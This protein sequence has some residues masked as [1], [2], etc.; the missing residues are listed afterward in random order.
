[1]ELSMR[2]RKELTVRQAR[3][4][5]QVSRAVKAK[6]LDE[7]VE[8][9]GYNRDYA[10]MLLRGCG[11]DRVQ[12]TG[13]GDSV[14]LVA[15]T[16]CRKAGGRPV[17][18]GAQVRR[19]VERLWVLFGHL[20]GK[21][22]VVLIREVLVSVEQHPELRISA[23]TCTALARVSA[24]TVDRMLHDQR[25]RLRLKGIS[26][27]KPTSALIA[28][29]PIR[30][31]TEWVGVGP[32]HLQIDLVGHDGGYASGEFCFT[33]VA[34]DVCSGWSELR[35]LRNKAAKWV[36]AALQEIRRELPFPV[37]E[38]HPD[39]GSE[40]L[41]HA[42]ADYCR[43]TQIR[44]TR[45]RPGRKND[46]CYVE[47]KNFDLVRK[48]VGYPR[49]EGDQAVELLN[50]LYRLGSSLW[51][52]YYPSQKLLETHRQGSTVRKRFDK[53]RSPARRLLDRNELSP[54][55]RW[56]LGVRMKQTDAIEIA[57]QV[58][59]LQSRVFA[60][61]IRHPVPGSNTTEVSA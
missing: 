5:R 32:G 25:V 29:I 23:T 55:Q 43:D 14:R 1:M 24:A 51:N 35:A 31:F 10:A 33:L 61:A 39:N 21:R 27:T 20:C 11:L 41:N 49:Y 30:T 18:Y 17:V 40:F 7:F 15:T 12:S 52:L 8:A 4:Y 58:R 45:S 50:Q 59:R 38:L 60:Q 9:T 26:H 19:A 57:G 16:G 22:L 37:V 46:N 44:L 2:S 47:Q 54:K 36:K 42:L 28:S 3:R 53:P 13:A 48:L 56:N 6:I 34:T